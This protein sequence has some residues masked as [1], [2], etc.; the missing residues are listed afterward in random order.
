MRVESYVGSGFI[1]QRG[2]ISLAED[3]ILGSTMGRAPRWNRLFVNGVV[4]VVVSI[5]GS[6]S[7]YVHVCPGDEALHRW[8]SQRVHTLTSVILC[9]DIQGF[10]CSTNHGRGDWTSQS[11]HGAEECRM[12]GKDDRHAPVSGVNTDQMMTI[13]G[14]GRPVRLLLW[15]CAM[16]GITTLVFAHLHLNRRV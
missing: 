14:L 8:F 5:L 15:L 2:R 13:H 7:L 10:R 11:L 4:R 1:V 12:K 3:G 6:T 9:S 16:T